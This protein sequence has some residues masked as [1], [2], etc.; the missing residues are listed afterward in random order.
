MNEQQLDWVR[1]Q[2]ALSVEAERGYTDLMGN[3]YRFSE[4]ICLSLGKP[5]RNIPAE[6]KIQWHDI[7]KKFA[8]YSNL[9]FSQRKQLVIGTRNFLHKQKAIAESPQTPP[10]PK[11]PRTKTLSSPKAK[12]YF[13]PEISLDMPLSKVIDIGRRSAYLE[14][15]G[16][17]TVRDLLFYYPRDHLDYA[18]QVKIAHLEPGETVTVIGTVKSCSSFTSQK[19][20]NLSI[21]KIVL[22]DPTGRL[23]INRF[24][25]GAR[26]STPG[27][28]ARERNKYPKNSIVG[29]WKLVSWENRTADGQVSYPFGKEAIGYILAHQ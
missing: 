17:Y 27:S 29:T 16:L 4:F 11:T 12:T 3:Q 20:K 18:R 8:D 5:P 9:S 13:N 19:N 26:Y 1:L 2:K 6:D 21:L 23:T 25:T 28:Q 10:K 22:A 14:R 15:L 7:A 24:L